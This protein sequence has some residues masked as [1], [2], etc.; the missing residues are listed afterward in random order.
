[1]ADNTHHDDA[2]AR[3]GQDMGA[4]FDQF[5]E[6]IETLRLNRTQPAA[7]DVNA[8]IANISSNLWAPRIES[9]EDEHNITIRAWLPD[10]PSSQIRI[11][12]GTHGRLK[13][14]G[15]RNSQVVYESGTD[16]ITERQLGQIE[17]SIPLPPEALVDQITALD[18]G[19][20]LVITVP[21]AAK[22]DNGA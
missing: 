3:T 5:F 6:S 17:K 4:L 14:Y 16:R 18:D 19:P 21:K 20:C 15:E 2:I 22:A 12:T 1:M 10:V 13:I 11:D 7:S 9:H 8:T